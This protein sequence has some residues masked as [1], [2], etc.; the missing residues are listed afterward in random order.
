M[1]KPKPKD[2]LVA[3]RELMDFFRWDIGGAVRGTQD[4]AKVRQARPIPAA[5][6]MPVVIAL[7]RFL[8]GETETLDDAFGGRTRSRRN[9]MRRDVSR[10]TVRWLV[11]AFADDA[12]RLRR[13]GTA[14]EDIAGAVAHQHNITLTSELHDFL[15]AFPSPKQIGVALTAA[16][17]GYTPST[18]EDIFNG[19]R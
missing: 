2:P 9:R 18:T 5:V 11:G 7:H 3:A 12:R 14:R 8:H 1:A 4:Y 6:L 19:E 13:K 17:L 15:G 16:H 10:D